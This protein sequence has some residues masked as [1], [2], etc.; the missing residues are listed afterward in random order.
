MS[1][2][3]LATTKGG[4]G[5]TTLARLILGRMAID[6]MRLA[7]VDADFN[8]TL[9][10]WLTSCAKFPVTVVHELNDQS[11][12]PLAIELQENHDIVIIDTAGAA[13][14]SALHAMAHSD[15]VLIPIQTSFADIVEAIKTHKLI[16]LLR[17][18]VPARVVLMSVQPATNIAEHI[19]AHVRKAGLPLL[20][21]HLSRLGAFQE[22]SFTG[23]V[24]TNGIAGQQT[25][26]LL[27]EIAELG[28]LP[29]PEKL[30]S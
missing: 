12:G 9:A 21:T 11:I 22:M 18:P 27:E 24:P 16:E 14:H 23:L 3:T 10:D 29:E 5:K 25:T 30:A 13:S 2:I 1:I 19:A 4:A 7:A 6:G 15:L 20:K 8:H 17:R 28:V 26:A